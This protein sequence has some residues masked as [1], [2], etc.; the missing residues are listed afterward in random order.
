MRVMVKVEEALLNLFIVGKG[1]AA[2]FQVRVLSTIIGGNDS[3]RGDAVLREFIDRGC[4][5][6]RQLP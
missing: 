3:S 1:V 2:G 5:L 4:G 6:V